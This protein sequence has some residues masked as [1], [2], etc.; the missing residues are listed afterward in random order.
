MINAF[1]AYWNLCIFRGSPAQVP[2]QNRELAILVAMILAIFAVQ[3]VSMGGENQLLFF[4]MRVL[5]AL[6][7]LTAVYISLRVRDLTNRFRK[8]LSAYLG[9]LAIADILTLLAFWLATRNELSTFIEGLLA[10]WRIAVFGSIL[11][12]SLDVS[13]LVGLLLAFGFSVISAFIVLMVLPFPIVG[14][15]S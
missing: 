3:S 12:H 9:T 10:L 2:S 7:V 14:V 6:L 13:L 1:A 4:G 15:E 5:L 8:T 11:R